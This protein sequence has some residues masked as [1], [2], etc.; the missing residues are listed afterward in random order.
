VPTPHEVGTLFDR[1]RDEFLI[2]KL[3][4]EEQQRILDAMQGTSRDVLL[5]LGKPTLL[6]DALEIEQV[7]AG[8]RAPLLAVQSTYHDKETPRFSLTPGATSLYLDMLRAQ[9][10]DVQVELLPGLGHFSMLEAP[11]AIS[12]AIGSFAASLKPFR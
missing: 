7:I 3:E 10:P 9:K 8:L 4:P 11:A 2:Q 6:W 1:V 12:C 5:A